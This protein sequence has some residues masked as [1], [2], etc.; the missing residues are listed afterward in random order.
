LGDSEIKKGQRQITLREIG[1]FRDQ[2]YGRL[3][4]IRRG[5]EIDSY[6]RGIRSCVRDS[7]IQLLTLCNQFVHERQRR[8]SR[9]E[10]RLREFIVRCRPSIGGVAIYFVSTSVAEQKKL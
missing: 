5:S 7:D 6:F 9:E 4:E 3:R 1:R 10:Q 8:E 2:L